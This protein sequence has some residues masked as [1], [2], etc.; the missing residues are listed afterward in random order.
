LVGIDGWREVQLED[1]AADITVGH[2]G[3]MAAEY[4]SSGIP[5]L[6]SQNVEP[7]VI[8][9][10]DVKFIGEEFHK[11]LANSALSPGDVVIV[12]TGK[13]GAAAVVP[14]SLPVS[15]CSD[16]V[17]VRPGPHLNSM[18]IAYYLNSLAV[19]HI[20][21]HLVGA[22][23]QHF[24][25]SSARLLRLRLP[26]LEEQKAIAAVL[27]ALDG[28]IALNRHMNQTLEA[29]ARAIFKSWIVDF[30][31]VKPSNDWRLSS[32]YS[33]ARVF[34]G[35]PFS[36]ALFNEKGVGKPLIRIRD[37]V[38]QTPTTFTTEQHSKARLVSPGDVLV[39]MDGEFKARIWCGPSAWLNQR[40]CLFEPKP[41]IPR[42]FLLYSLEEPLAFFER[43]KTGTTVIHLGKADIDTFRILLPASDILQRFG[44]VT[45][46]MLDKIVLNKQESRT[47]AAI[48]D[49]L[50]PKLLSGEI[51]VKQ[52]E[53]IV[54]E[55]A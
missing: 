6:R 49:A 46:P 11:R 27:G 51:R 17:I 35:A 14:S 42:A 50:L 45:D 39:G 48:R 32:I 31:Y 7:Y 44:E 20:A 3:P 9:T 22:V 53:R 10:N 25:V 28:K 2:V 29:M 21:S 40:V 52:A 38:S 19:H 24:N 8:Q 1:V 13:P 5:F 26:P 30:E 54:E 43:S 18:F 37:L 23:Q 47:L 12:R 41:H 36:S 34:Y 55:V 4:R 33:I 16:L 15:N